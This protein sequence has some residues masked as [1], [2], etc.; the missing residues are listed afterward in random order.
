MK[1]EN[2]IA[3]GAIFASVLVGLIALLLP[4]PPESQVGWLLFHA[5]LALTLMYGCLHIGSAIL[6][7]TSLGA[8]KSE[9]RRVYIAIS[10]GIVVL[11]LGT[12]QVAIIAA[13]NWWNTPWAMDGY[14]VVPFLAAGMIVYIGARGLGKLIGIKSLL[15]RSS[16]VLPSVFITSLLVIFIPHPTPT[17]TLIA[18]D[19][20]NIITTWTMLMF[21]AAGLTFVAITRHIGAHYKAAMGWLSGGFISAT[22]VLACAVGHTIVAPNVTNDTF[23]I[24][25]DFIG[26]IAG[27]VYVRA[28][29]EFAKTKDL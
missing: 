12:L 24:I 6:F 25:T 23:S 9:L 22:L 26:V 15:V 21:L 10:A 28:A 5:P 13:F 27:L 4:T 11:A 16:A 19:A 3:V 7:L 20:S 17:T 8:Y 14:I 29:Y 1:R 18:Y 2:V